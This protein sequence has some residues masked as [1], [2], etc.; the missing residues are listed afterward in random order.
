[1]LAARDLIRIGRSARL[2][3]HPERAERGDS[4][5]PVPS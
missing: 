3:A 2:P 1:M 4:D 5:C